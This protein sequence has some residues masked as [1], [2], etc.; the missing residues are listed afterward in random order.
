MD[1]SRIRTSNNFNKWRNHYRKELDVMYSI[2]LDILNVRYDNQGGMD[3]R[4]SPEIFDKIV[5]QNSSNA[6][7]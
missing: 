3:S 7:I 2:V 1:I 6:L 4:I 5:F